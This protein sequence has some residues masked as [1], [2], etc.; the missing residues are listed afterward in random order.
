M[1]QAVHEH[2]IQ[3]ILRLALPRGP[4]AALVQRLAPG[5]RLVRAQRLRGGI[6]SRMDV[7]H[8]D[9]ADG[10]REKVSLRRL[11][12]HHGS[13]ED[14]VTEFEVLRLLQGAGIAAPRPILLDARSEIF[15]GP[16]LVISYLP[17][18]VLF[19][20]DGAG[21]AAWTKGIAA[22]LHDVHQVTPKRFDLS[23]LRVR[24]REWLRS[25][26]EGRREALQRDPLGAEV[27]A[28][29][30]AGIERIEFREATLVHNDFWWANVIWYRSRVAGIVD[31]GGAVLGDPRAD[32]AE[33]RIGF[34]LSHPLAVA[35][36]FR[37]AYEGAAGRKLR[38]LWF[39]DLYRG[40][41]A[42]L[43]YES[44]LDGYHDLGVPRLE[45]R[46]VRARLE[47]FMRRAL[48][49]GRAS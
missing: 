42:L 30:A 19:V 10:T 32:V 48:E 6:S 34:V 43:E 3:A 25:R 33:G 23:S 12:G 21:I 44:W 38:D 47:A 31:W 17:G 28:A 11:L 16:A 24:S 1:T 5:G 46:D 22:A 37:D 14:A 8:I 2:D 40:G 39:F 35:D 29:L 41:G 36:A 4:L 27:H 9:R 13:P 49:E 15:G 26:I 45:A 7:L 18:R 20:P